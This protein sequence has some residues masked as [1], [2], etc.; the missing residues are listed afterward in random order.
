[1]KKNNHRILNII[2]LTVIIAVGFIPQIIA[3]ELPSVY[4]DPFVIGGQF[5][6]YQNYHQVPYFHGGMDLCAPAGTSAY[7]PISGKI[8]IYLYQIDAGKNPLR[9]VYKRASLRQKGHTRTRYLEIAIQDEKQNI[10][11][12]RHIDP[13]TIPDEL[14]AAANANKIIQKGQLM[15]KV[16]NWPYNVN[17]EPVKY[18]HIHMEIHD[19]NGFYLDPADYVASPKDYYPPVIHN[20]FLVKHNSDRAFFKYPHPV[21]NGK[22]DIVAQVNDR[23]NRSAYQHSVYKVFY[24][25]DKIDSEGNSL[26]VIE[27]TCSYYFHTL[28]ISGDRTKLVQTVYPDSIRQ[29]GRRFQANGNHGPRIFLLNLSAGNINNGYNPENCIDTRRLENGFYRCTV[30]AYDHAG[31]SKTVFQDFVIKN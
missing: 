4:K 30:E 2:A 18:T 3:T 26:P 5:Y 22:I 24:Q 9:F 17:P 11:M 1:M 6:D 12:F 19:K 21:V 28:P 14:F 25:I 27:K 31:N 8:K 10:W 15:G 7:S 29:A 13:Q 20:I 16:G 23:M